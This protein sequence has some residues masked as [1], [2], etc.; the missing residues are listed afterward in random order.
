MF[1]LKITLTHAILVGLV[2]GGAHLFV[3]WDVKPAMTEN[4]ELSLRRAALIAEQTKR[5]DHFALQA[6]GDMVAG[7]QNIYEYLTLKREKLLQKIEEAEVDLLARDLGKKLGDAGGDD[8]APNEEEEGESGISTEDLRHLAVHWRLLVAKNRFERV[9]KG[10]A[11]GARNIARDLLGRNPVQPDLVAVVDGEG[12]SVAALGKDRYAWGASKDSWNLADEYPALKELLN[13]PPRSPRLD[14]WQWKWSKDG[15]PK[16]YQVAVVP[17]P[18]RRDDGG[19][20]EASA[21]GAVIVGYPITDGAAEDIRTLVGGVT[22][23]KQKRAGYIGEKDLP[24]VAFFHGSSVHSSTFGPDRQKKLGEEFFQTNRILEKDKPEQVVDLTLD[25]SEYN[26]FVRFLPDQFETEKPTGVVVLANMSEARAPVYS[27]LQKLNLAAGIA[28]VLGIA[29]LLFFYYRFIKPLGEIEETIG[30]ILSGN[31]D[32]EFFVSKEGSVFESIA[33]GL[34]LVSAFLQDKPMPDE[35]AD[36]GDWGDLAG[37]P[38]DAGGGGGGGDGAS[39]DVQ[40]VQ[41]P[42]MGGGDDDE[43]S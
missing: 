21:D 38:D 24:D 41:M 29:L 11:S 16:L 2:L 13:T 18:R 42:G 9:G 27:A 15:S 37:G 22:A 4:A 23:D 36:L 33:Q 5:L 40:G 26:A 30:E 28:I 35:E 34:N 3:S 39:P 19:R 43:E 31:K 14:V 17:I 32:A 10:Q 12:K 7:D 20:V 1:R 8:A 6:K 25:G